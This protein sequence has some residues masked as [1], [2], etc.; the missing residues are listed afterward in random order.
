[1]PSLSLSLSRRTIR[2]SLTT[3]RD[4]ILRM[5]HWHGH[6]QSTIQETTWAHPAIQHKPSR[7]LSSRPS[8]PTPPLS[9]AGGRCRNPSLGRRLT[10]PSL[11]S[12]RP[13]GGESRLNLVT[14]ARTRGSNHKARRPPG[15]QTPALGSGR[16]QR[17]ALSCQK[18]DGSCFMKALIALQPA[19]PRDEVVVPLVG[20]DGDE[21]SDLGDGQEHGGAGLFCPVVRQQRGDVCVAFGFQ[22]TFQGVLVCRRVPC[23]VAGIKASRLVHYLVCR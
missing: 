8:R 16:C 11:L 5:S 1:M 18:F 4:D 22:G 9:R 6:V 23:A 10:R 2:T 7:D 13:L 19:R 14:F 21:I 12:C 17:P 20:L 3:S 15:W